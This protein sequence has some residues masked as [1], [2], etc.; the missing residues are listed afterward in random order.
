M[1][2][3]TIITDNCS[4]QLPPVVMHYQ[5]DIC[6]SVCEYFMSSKY[7]P[8]ILVNPKIKTPQ[9]MVLR[10]VH[11]H[12][13]VAISSCVFS[14]LWTGQLY[15]VTYLNKESKEFSF[16]TRRCNNIPGK[17]HSTIYI[18][19]AIFLSWKKCISCGGVRAWVLLDAGSVPE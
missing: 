3:Q 17:M 16:S 8:R 18:C 15:C 12:V 7:R 13:R 11:L 9:V 6:L 14:R 2:F 5:C 10:R 19:S 4:S 1:S